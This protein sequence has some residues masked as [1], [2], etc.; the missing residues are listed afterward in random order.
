VVLIV[1]ENGVAVEFIRVAYDVEAAR[2]IL[3]SELPNDFAEVLR[4]GG[5]P[6]VSVA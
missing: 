5:R 3:A 4:T 6:A 2:G 1:N